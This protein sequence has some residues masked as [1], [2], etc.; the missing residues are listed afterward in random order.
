LQAA[1]DAAFPVRRHTFLL[2]ACLTCLSGMV[3]L[4]V[5]V[6]TI[7]LVLVTG[8]EGI[9]GLGPAIFLASGA[10]AALPAG[11]A[12]DHVGRVPVLAA[13]FCSGAAGCALAAAG[14]RWDSALLVISGFVLVGAASGTVLLARAAAADLYPPERRARGI[15]LVLFGALFGA[16]LG[17]LVF[18]PLFA[19]KELDLD[20]LV[21]PYLAA[22]GIML[23]GLALVLAI[24]PDPKEIALRIAAARSSEPARPAAPLAV[25]LRRPGVPTALLS[26]L[27]SFAVMVGIMNLTGYVVV[28]HGHEQA[29]VFSVISAHIVGMYALVLVIGRVIDGV[30]RRPSL[31]AGLAMMAVSTLA[32]AW[33]ASV[34]WASVALFGLGLGWNVSY[35]AA[36]TEL[37]DS[38]A[39]AERGKLIGFTDLLSSGFGATLAL[40]GGVVYSEVG[41]EAL[42]VGATVMALA[43]ALWILLRGTP[44]PLPEAG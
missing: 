37:A 23:I 44:R 24:R 20:A 28:G 13:G 7:T 30:G 34:F 18:R 33:F 41:V 1:T 36:S 2:A 26:A 40:V 17:P 9:L 25:V 11:R 14:C 8:V 42:A 43:P 31:I 10:V 5:A 19:G 38:A 16:A 32:L 3:Q 22:G 21:V 39:P 15:S 27:T 4:V 6:A 12:M 29:D 35:V